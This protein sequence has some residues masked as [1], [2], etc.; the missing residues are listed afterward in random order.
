M[1]LQA[2][3]VIPSSLSQMASFDTWY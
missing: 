3:V 2:I 1:T